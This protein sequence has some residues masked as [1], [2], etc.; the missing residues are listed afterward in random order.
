MS[1]RP[2]LFSAPM[3]RAI[4]AGTK[5]QT[6]RLVTK[7]TAICGSAPWAWLRF[8][9]A[10]PTTSGCTLLVP[11]DHPDNPGDGAV[12]RVR[13]RIQPADRL[14]V[15]ETWTAG[16]TDDNDPPRTIGYVANRTAVFFDEP[17]KPVPIEGADLLWAWERLRNR[18][19]IFMPRWASRIALAVKEVRVER[20]H[21]I[22][23][24]DARAEGVEAAMF[25]ETWKY[26][27]EDPEGHG[28]VFDAMAPL[29]EE[30][31]V[32]AG[33]RLIFHHKPSILSS[34]R[35]Q[36]A[37]LWDSINRNRAPWASNPFVWVVRFSRVAAAKGAA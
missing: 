24:E 34:A 17:D 37:Q 35:D 2:I 30:E 33:V 36:Y 13:P 22:T 16:P 18:P 8:D 15:R 3:V 12:H 19:S 14:W 4:L 32:E 6:R 26:I 21:D 20:L 9:E 5:T 28:G 1:E 27:H 11:G 10:S 23:E 31:C 25:S 29:S 7:G